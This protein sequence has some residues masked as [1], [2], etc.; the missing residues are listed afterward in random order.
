MFE[1]VRDP[2]WNLAVQLM[3]CEFV[4]IESWLKYCY[5]VSLNPSDDWLIDD[6]MTFG[7]VS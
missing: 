1:L 3:K 4:L 2:N 7:T 5:E 6:K